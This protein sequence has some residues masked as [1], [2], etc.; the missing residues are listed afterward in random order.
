MCL[1]TTLC[2]WVVQ[3]HPARA[4]PGTEP[5]TPRT[6]DAIVSQ[7]LFEDDSGNMTYEDVLQQPFAPFDGLLGEGYGTSTFWVKLRIDPARVAAA[8]T[9]TLYLRIRPSYLD[10]LV[11]YDPLQQPLRVGPI[12]DAYPLSSQSLKSTRFTFPLPAGSAP[13]DIWVELKSTSTRLARFEVLDANTLSVSNAMIDIAG[14]LYLGLLSL[15]TMWGL[16]QLFLRPEPLMLCFVIYLAS[17]ALFGSSMLGYTRLLVGDLVDPFWIDRLTSILGIVATAFAMLFDYFL[18]KEIRASRWRFGVKA[19]LMSIFLL[20][21]A[22]LL[23]GHVSLALQGNMIM[24]LLAPIVLWVMAITN[25]PDTGAT[26]DIGA[27]QRPWIVAYFSITVVFTLVAAAP[28]LGLI[29]ASDFS[30]YIVLFYSATSGLL[31]LMMLAYRAHI[32][33]RHQQA[34]AAKA[35][36]SEQRAEQERAHRLDREKLLA[37][38]GHEL[39]TPMATLRMLANHQNIPDHLSKRMDA[40]VREMAEV[41]DRVVQTGQLDDQATLVR[42]RPC[43]LNEILQALINNVPASDQPRVHVTALD[44]P[45]VEINT[46]PQMLGIILRNLL[47]NAL[48]YGDPD[49]PINLRFEILATPDA[50]RAEITNTPGR[51]GWPDADHMFKKYYRS[52]KA[53]YRTG[54]GLGLYIVQELSNMLGAKV[55]YAPDDKQVRFVVQHDTPAQEPA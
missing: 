14:S 3:V 22:I 18:I 52:A 47:D 38:I 27:L 28:A 42:N 53:S 26:H 15:F 7:M 46:D 35:L 55:V 48:K 16:I 21:L 10:M 29:K 1:L 4:T 13:R 31:M 54:S 49:A 6:A 5:G 37:M 24:I 40:S 32:L 9:D 50:W 8:P 34:Q 30:L 36:V 45:E 2:L 12:G 51:A 11:L 20:L 23:S 33:F 19:V 41:V 17:A 44:N 25:R 43:K 39:K